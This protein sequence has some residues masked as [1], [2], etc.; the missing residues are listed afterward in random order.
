MFSPGTLGSGLWGGCSF[1][2]ETGYLYINANNAPKFFT[3]VDAPDAELYPYQVTG[4]PYF[5]DQDGYPA[6]K[7][8]WGELLCLDLAT[9]EYRWRKPLGEHAALKAK[10]IPQTGT[11]T[12]GGSIVTKGG[13]LLIGATCDEKFRAFDSR[14]GEMLWEHQFEAG[15]YATPSTYLVAGKQY[16]VIAQ[17]VQARAGRPQETSS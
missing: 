16:I 8:P 13:L 2:P 10:G 6:S 15:G 11:F 7:P 17:V 4:Y 5:N 14:T 9:T 3:L 12:V 1:D